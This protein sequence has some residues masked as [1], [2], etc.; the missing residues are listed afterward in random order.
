MLGLITDRNQS[1]VDRLNALAKKGWDNLSAAERAEWT[2]DPLT[3]SDMGYVSPVNLLP[4]GTYIP[5]GATAKFRSESMVVTATENS[6]ANYA[7]IIVGNAENYINRMFTLSLDHVFPINGGTP[8][9]S[10]YWYSDG[11]S[12]EYAGVSLEEPGSQTSILTEGEGTLPY[13]AAFVYAGPEEGASVLYSGARLE[14]DDGSNSRYVP[15]TEI[16]PTAATKGAYNYSDWNRVERAV[17]ELSELLALDLVT[18]TD[19]TMWDI[20]TESDAERFLRNIEIVRSV[21]PNIDVPA[22]P[23]GLR[24]LSFE[25]ANDIEKILEGVY[26]Y[27]ASVLRSGELFC[28]EV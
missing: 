11:G 9:I 21:A 25:T 1:N 4:A 20:P 22:V 10:L 3:A 26:K 6:Q 18:K 7:V 5:H 28:G 27:A 19:W 2:G 23:G 15:Y 24:N 8:E 13:L 16:L 12:Y 17:S 14:I